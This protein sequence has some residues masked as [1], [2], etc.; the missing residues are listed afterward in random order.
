MILL[1]GIAG[2]GKGTQGSLLAEK[3]GYNV[4]STG[5]LLRNYGSEEQHA[6]MHRGVIL[7]DAEVTAL[8]DRALGELPDADKV[9][10]DGYPRRISQADWLLEQQKK[11]KFKLS[12][13][14][15]LVASPKSVK[16]RLHDRGRIDDHDEAIEERFREYDRATLPILTHLANAGVPVN[17]IDAERPVEAVHN[18]IVGLLKD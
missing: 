13:I 4:I 7:D 10:L 17:Q 2:S 11:G 18:D 8:L 1:M 15:H 3:A 16:D 14:L 5:D 12:Q 6:R 9:I